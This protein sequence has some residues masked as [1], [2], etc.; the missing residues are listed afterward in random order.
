[1]SAPSRLR[2]Q[3]LSDHPLCEY[4]LVAGSHFDFF[5]LYGWVRP[6]IVPATEVDHIFGRRGPSDA[7]EH[8]SNYIAAHS[9]PHKWK[10][11]NSVA[12][13]I[14]AVAW[15]YRRR[16][17]DPDGWDLDRMRE[18]FGRNILGW[19]EYRLDTLEMPQWVVNLGREVLEGQDAQPEQRSEGGP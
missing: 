3:Y 6:R 9:L 12:G 11:D 17:A 2:Q 10:T 7:V 1:M 19:M 5:N 14:I 18:V 13:R 15:K 8:S 4:S 16:H